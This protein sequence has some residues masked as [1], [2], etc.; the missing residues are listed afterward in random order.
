[1]KPG[2]RVN[3][4]F[5]AVIFAWSKKWKQEKNEIR[6]SDDFNM[7]WGGSFLPCYRNEV[8]GYIIL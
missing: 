3:L 7:K 8:R 6:V 4:L 2:K 1:M 5:A